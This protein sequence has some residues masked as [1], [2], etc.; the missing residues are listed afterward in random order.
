MAATKAAQ[1]RKRLREAE[2][3]APHRTRVQEAVAIAEQA[4]EA[5]TPIDAPRDEPELRST[6]AQPQPFANVA[7]DLNFAAA[8]LTFEGAQPQEVSEPSRA[9]ALPAWAG[10]DRSDATAASDAQTFDA[11]AAVGLTIDAPAWHGQP[12]KL[13]GYDTVQDRD[14]DSA[15]VEIER[16]QADIVVGTL[17]SV[18]S[19]NDDRPK[20]FEKGGEA[21]SLRWRVPAS[22]DHAL[23]V[24]DGW[25][26]GDDA[27]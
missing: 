5:A 7:T 18:R 21:R 12:G 3:T 23:F 27:P 20:A 16:G 8:G 2:A 9:A 1:E 25:S 26:L 15:R 4:R 24:G 6:S 14:T 11:L 13:P 19:F 17:P 22:P 10:G